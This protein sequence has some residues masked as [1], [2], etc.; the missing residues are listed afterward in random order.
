MTD[1][2]AIAGIVNGVNIVF[3]A[4]IRHLDDKGIMPKDRL[5]ADMETVVAEEVKAHRPL[6]IEHVLFQNLA[7]LLRDPQGGGWKPI[8][9]E[10]SRSPDTEDQSSH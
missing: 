4:I 1:P 8:V 9:I 6:R 2:A 10:G 5:A 3:N 7:K